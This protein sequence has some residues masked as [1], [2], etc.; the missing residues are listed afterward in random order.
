MIDSVIV[1]DGTSYF[2]ESIHYVLCQDETI[3]FRGSFAKCEA[4][5]DTFN[6]MAFDKP[7]GA[8]G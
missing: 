7:R 4:K 5:C 1:F 6:D 3:V 8:W 2:V